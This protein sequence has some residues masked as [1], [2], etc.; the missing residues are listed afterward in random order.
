MRALVSIDAAHLFSSPGGQVFAWFFRLP[1]TDFLSM[2][3]SPAYVFG[4][5]CTELEVNGYLVLSVIGLFVFLCS[6]A[7]HVK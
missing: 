3:Q 6:A 2:D 7:A 1:L 5:P 4:L